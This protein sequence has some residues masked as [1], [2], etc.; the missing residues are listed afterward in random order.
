MKRRRVSEVKLRFGDDEG[1]D[2]CDNNA[3]ELTVN[4]KKNQPSQ[5]KPKDDYSIN[6][7]PKAKSIDKIN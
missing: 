6:E 2:E 4:P 5:A 1:T 3:I 7:D